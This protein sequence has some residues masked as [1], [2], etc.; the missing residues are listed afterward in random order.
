[1]NWRISALDRLT[2]ISNSDAHSPEKLAR[3]SNLLDAPLSYQGIFDAFRRRGNS[4]LVKTLEF[5]PEEGKYHWD[6]H[7]DCDESYP[8]EETI[9]RKGICSKCR[10]PVTVGVL[11]QIEKLADRK[12]GIRPDGAADFEN[13]VPL[14]EIISQVLQVGTASKRVDA[15][16][17]QMLE[18]FGTEFHI[19]REVPTEQI[20][21]WGQPLAARA[22]ERMRKGD[23]DVPGFDGEFG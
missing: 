18:K 21:S 2:L 23:A 20:K 7:R 19:L 9:R 16:Y 8:P 14:K 1:M 5:F 4:K 22:L 12:K 13:I 6:G 10:R 11:Y 15:L 17:H 3:E